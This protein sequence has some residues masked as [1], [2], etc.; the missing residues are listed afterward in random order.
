[1]RAMKMENIEVT[2]LHFHIGSQILDMTDF[3]ALCNR[4]NELQDKLEAAHITLPN[5]N[6]GG[7]LGVSYDHPNREAIPDFAS[8]FATYA[9]HLKL[10]NGQRLHFELGRAVVAQCGSLITRAL[11][12]KQGT[13]KQFLILDAGMTD[14]IRPAL[15][16]PTT[17]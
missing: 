11:Y 16:Q 17:R 9:R 12:I 2:G 3:E 1:M 15:Y 5:I 13:H 14:L 8:Y 7:G 6:V 4:I 10:R